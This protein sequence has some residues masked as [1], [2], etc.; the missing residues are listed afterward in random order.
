MNEPIAYAIALTKQIPEEAFRLLEP[1]L[2]LRRDDY[3]L[4]SSHFEYDAGFL[5]LMLRHVDA[6]NTTLLRVFIPPHY[7][8]AVEVLESE[9]D[10]KRI[11]FHS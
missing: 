3:Y 8:L 1:C 2:F 11:G 5:K 4:L 9:E 6:N 7:V 10:A